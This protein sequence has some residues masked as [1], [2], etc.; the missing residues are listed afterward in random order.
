MAFEQ[1]KD[2]RSATQSSKRFK[3]HKAKWSLG[4]RPSPGVQY[5]IWNPD[6]FLTGSESQREKIRPDK[7][8]SHGRFQSHNIV[9]PRNA[10][11]A[12]DIPQSHS[13]AKCDALTELSD[14]S[15][16]SRSIHDMLPSLEERRMNGSD[17]V[18]YSFDRAETPGKPLSLDVFFKTNPRETEKFVEKEYEIL[19]ANGEALK[20]RKARRDLRRQSPHAIAEEPGLIEDEGFELV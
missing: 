5:S 4:S 18:L 12:H 8:L 6:V 19:D 13:R 17:N 10:R 7:R 1:T 15:N 3:E 20:G 11:I 9:K 14:P 16:T 2:F